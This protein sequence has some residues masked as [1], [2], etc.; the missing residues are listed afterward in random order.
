METTEQ[1]GYKKGAFAAWVGILGN[2]VLAVVKVFGGIFGCS[3]ALIAD[4][5]HSL[6]DSI[7]SVA[8]LI[9][10]RLADRPPDKNHPYGHGRAETIAGKAVSMML[11]MFALFMI[12]RSVSE[13]FNP[14]M[15]VVPERMKLALVVGVLSILVKELMFRYK[16]RLGKAIGSTSLIADAWHHRS[17]AITSPLVVAG[18]L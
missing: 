10:M 14:T 3:A 16:Y 6:T 2:L 8:V 5:A 12:Y 9:G 7:S 4:A 13:I 15:E 11:I 1:T 17:D 18:F